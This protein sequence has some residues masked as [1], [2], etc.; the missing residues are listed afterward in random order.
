M[1]SVEYGVHSLGLITCSYTTSTIVSVPSERRDENTVSL[2]T[3]QGDRGS[4]S[5]RQVIVTIGCLSHLKV[6]IGFLKPCKIINHWSVK[7]KGHRMIIPD[8]DLKQLHQVVPGS[9]GYLDQTDH[10]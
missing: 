8:L 5:A 2:L 6:S 1:G 10:R 4:Q 3:I 9:G 7:L